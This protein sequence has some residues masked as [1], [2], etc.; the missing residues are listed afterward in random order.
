MDYTA[1]ITTIHVY[2]CDKDPPISKW[3]N[4]YLR[5]PHF[6]PPFFTPYSVSVEQGCELFLYG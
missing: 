6:V 2:L 4:S 1:S 3:D 5:K